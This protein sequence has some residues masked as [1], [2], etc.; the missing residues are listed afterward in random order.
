MSCVVLPSF[1][2]PFERPSKLMTG[3]PS[4]SLEADARFSADNLTVTHALE[5]ASRNG[6]S[7][8]W[9]KL[10]RKWHSLLVRWV[11]TVYQLFTWSFEQWDIHPHRYGSKGAKILAQCSAWHATKQV[12]ERSEYRTLIS[13]I[14]QKEIDRMSKTQVLSSIIISASLYQKQMLLL[15]LGIVY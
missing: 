1:Q 12:T 15:L 14:H 13:I 10:K 8:F 6:R 2:E 11:S 9:I 4:S 5:D 3:L 7:S